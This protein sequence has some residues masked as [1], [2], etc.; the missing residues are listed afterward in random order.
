MSPSDSTV[1][2][3]AL[4]ERLKFTTEEKRALK[5]F[6]RALARRVAG[7]H[8]FTCLITDDAELRRLNSEFLGHDYATDVLSFPA[9]SANGS[10]G[11]I[12]ISAER[13][14]AQAQEFKH[15]R[16]EEVRILML[17]GLLHLT[18]LDHEQDRGEMAQAETKWRTELRLPATLIARVHERKRNQ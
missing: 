7:G 15:S 5:Q 6:A 14:E 8:A 2:F 3:G 4:P 17:H 18:G 1:L 10:L 16:L 12:A 9:L 13:A 11:E